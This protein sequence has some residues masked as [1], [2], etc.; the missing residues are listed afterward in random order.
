M[1][2]SDWVPEIQ[3]AADL[4][5]RREDYNEL[6]REVAQLINMQHGVFYGALKPLNFIVEYGREHG[7]S[8]LEGL[9]ELLDRKNQALFPQDP[10]QVYQANYMRD[11]RRRLRD[12]VELYESVVGYRLDADERRNFRSRQQNI[13]MQAREK[14]MLQSGQVPLEQRN[15]L[16]RQFWEQVDRDLE[17]AHAGDERAIAAFMKHH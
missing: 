1:S 9:W 15:E 17:R 8:Q 5:V 3:Q 16:S 10:K 13:W 12:A 4:M 14:L 7:A 2:S 6:K 11:R